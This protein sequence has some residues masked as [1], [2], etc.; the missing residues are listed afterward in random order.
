MGLPSINKGVC[1]S[2]WMDE[3]RTKANEPRES[4][5]IKLMQS[6]R[7]GGEDGDDD[8]GDATNEDG[9]GEVPKQ[10]C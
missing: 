3:M 8:G 6:D 7:E 9:D 2:V 1:L 5:R 10:R 4:P